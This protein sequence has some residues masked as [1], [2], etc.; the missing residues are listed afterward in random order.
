[1]RNADLRA[2]QAGTTA[3]R[4]KLWSRLKHVAEIRHCADCGEKYLHHHSRQRFCS[5]VCT[6]RYHRRM[7]A[8]RA[9]QRKAVG[10][11][12]GE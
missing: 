7:S 12:R 2:W 3:E 11:S 5:T 1:M 8:R 10:G 6:D 9:R 4:K